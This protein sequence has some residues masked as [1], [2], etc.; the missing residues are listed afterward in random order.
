M[1]CALSL[2]LNVDLKEVRH[3][4]V[5]FHCFDS[6]I[7]FEECH[8]LFNHF[9][10]FTW[11]F[12]VYD[13][14]FLK[15]YHVM[16]ILEWIKS[17]IHLKWNIHYVH[18]PSWSRAMSLIILLSLTLVCGLFAAMNLGWKLN[19]C[20][21]ATLSRASA[22]RTAAPTSSSADRHTAR[23]HSEP[24]S[25]LPLSWWDKYEKQWLPCWRQKTCDCYW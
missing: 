11:V 16:S 3:V 17:T 2:F 6:L 12:V 19:R 1:Q 15:K 23:R 8:H 5:I 14:V 10:S 20:A 22:A 7:L 4:C 21:C 24:D 25:S 18:K 9:K 13:S